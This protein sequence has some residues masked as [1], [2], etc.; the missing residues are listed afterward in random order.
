MAPSKM[1]D[2]FKMRT[3]FPDLRLEPESHSQ[4]L[5]GRKDR[6]YR[7]ELLGGIEEGYLGGE[8]H[9]AV[10]YGDYGR[11]KTHQAHNLI[12]EVSH[13]DLPVKPVYV[14]C[15]EYAKK[16]PFSELFS[17]MIG[18]IGTN[19]VQQTAIEFQRRVTN[20]ESKPLA[21]LLNDEEISQ[22]FG[23]LSNP[24][25]ATVRYAIRWLSGDIS[26]TKGE[27]DNLP[28]GMGPAVNVSSQYAEVMRGFAHM[29]RE[30][31]DQ[32]LIFMIDEAERLNQITHDDTFWSWNAC[33][34]EL[35]EIVGVGFIFLV[36]GKTRDDVPVLLTQ[37]EVLTRIGS[38]NFKDIVN[39]GH[40]ELKE[41]ILELL[42]TFFR[43]GPVPAPLTQAVRDLAGDE[44]VDDDQAAEEI[45]DL[46]GSEE[47]AL[48]AYPFTPAA[49]DQFVTQCVTEEL[50]NKPRE[51]LKRMRKAA[52]KAI[53]QDKRLIDEDIV[54]E[55]QSG[56]F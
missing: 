27:R 46:T 45:A 5:F 40:D 15:T 9:K 23:V 22:V 35:M 26:L 41:W 39:P 56:G 24:N 54:D 10:R 53:L 12:Y 8:G 32:T 20:D 34:R 6:S 19:E 21:G 38:T 3:G 49:L 16:A 28:Q 36:G 17:V 50:A 51:V 18:A 7:D 33:F 48:Q 25:I 55:I 13:R 42:Q 2:W 44:A 29:Y 11:G 43:K 47:G 14:K 31:H 30:V 1:H 52:A 37:P 4:L